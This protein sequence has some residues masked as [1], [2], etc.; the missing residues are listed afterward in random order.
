MTGKIKYFNAERGFGFIRGDDGTDVFLHI[1]DISSFNNRSP[2]EGQEVRYEI[3]S[4]TKGTKA[5]DAVLV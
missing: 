3:G 5:I 2:V 1:T 4:C